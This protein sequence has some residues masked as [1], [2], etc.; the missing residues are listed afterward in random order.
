M[1][2]AIITHAITAQPFNPHK[3]EDRAYLASAL[4]AY[5][6]GLRVDD[7]LA[8]DQRS[9]A[10]TRARYIAM[11]LVY[12]GLGLSLARA[13]G[14]DR[15]TVAHGCRQIESLRDEDEFDIWIEQLIVGLS[16]VAGLGALREIA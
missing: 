4:V 14:R 16:S 5:A 9:V 8:A 10:S 12:V 6:L 15:S 11:Y 3:D 7:I 2:N 1:S 13:F